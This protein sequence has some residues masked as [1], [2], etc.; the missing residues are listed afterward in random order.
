MGTDGVLLASNRAFVPGMRLPELNLS[1]ICSLTDDTG[2]IQHALYTIPNRKEGY[3]IDDNARALF[4]TVCACR[5]REDPIARRLLSIYLS[6]IHYMQTEDGYFINFLSYSRIGLEVRG[7][8]DSFGRTIM[9]LGYLVNESP[10]SSLAHVGLRIFEKAFQHIDH[11][12]SL[13][14]IANAL[15]GLCQFFK[16][17]SLGDDDQQ[18]LTCL[19]GKLVALYK[20][21]REDH[22]QW[23]EPILAYDNAML[24]LSLLH[25]YEITGT[26][27]YLQ[28]A[29]EATYF[30][31]SK[32]WHDGVLRPIGNQGWCR[33]NGVSAQ[34]DQQGI[35]AMAMVLLYHQ[36]FRLTREQQYLHK[37]YKSYQWFVGDNDMGLSLYDPSTGGCSD[38]LQD[39]RINLN[40]GAE[41]TL[42]YWISHFIVAAAMVE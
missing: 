15:I 13:R 4:L 40:Q 12:R 2:I 19:A 31:E 25:A 10:S 21:N 29:M 28:I 23:F 7:S 39:G 42:A 37:M 11:L 36:V 41:S 16:C 35:D 20:V 34:F 27:E 18:R 1:H 38:G 9:A 6:F 22:W 3:C 8:E 17:S 33:K 30:L 26:N 5:S 32:V 14:G 24:P